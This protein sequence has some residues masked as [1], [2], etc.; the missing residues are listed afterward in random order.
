[1]RAGPVIWP[2][3][4]SMYMMRLCMGGLLDRRRRKGIAI[5]EGEAGEAPA[6]L[7]LFQK[8]R[9]G[10]S[11]ALPLSRISFENR[12]SGGA[13][14]SRVRWETLFCAGCARYHPGTSKG[15]AELNLWRTDDESA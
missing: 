12:G 11:L 13:S 2:A 9:L 4:Y 14:P 5:W 1:M 8:P 7:K 3:L 15:V 10:R 6:E